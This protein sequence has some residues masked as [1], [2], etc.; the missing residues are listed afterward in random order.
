MGP[1]RPGPQPPPWGH[2]R[3][4]LSE[5]PPAL[6]CPGDKDVKSGDLRPV[7]PLGSRC[8]RDTVTGLERIGLG[9]SPS[10]GKKLGDLEAISGLLLCAQGRI[11]TVL[12]ESIRDN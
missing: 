10:S 1:C 8:R 12:K 11:N 2:S 7:D 3:C 5:G 4:L 9:A 6:V